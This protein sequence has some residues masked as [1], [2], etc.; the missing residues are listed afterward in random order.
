MTTHFTNPDFLDKNLNARDYELIDRI[1]SPLVSGFIAEFLQLCNP[2]SAYVSCGKPE[3]LDYVRKKAL[4][5]R[6]ELPLTIS[7]HTVH[8]DNYLDQARD[9]EHSKILVPKPEDF[10]LGLRLCDRELCYGEV[11][12]LLRDIMKGREMFISFYSLGPVNSYFSIPCI[13]IT[14]SSYVVHSENILYRQG[15]EEFVRLGAG[16]RPFRFLH[17]EGALDSNMTSRNL[18]KRRVYIDLED[19]TVYSINTQYAGNTIGLKKLG[20]RLAIRRASMEGWLNEHMFIMAVHGPQGRR[21]YFTGAFP[22]MCGKTSTAMIE[23]ESIV[24]DD[25]AFLRAREGAIRA[26]NTEKGMFGIIKDVNAK[27]DPPLWRALNSPGDVIFS[28][29]LTTA[30]G[31][32][33][34]E[35]MGVP[36]PDNGRNHSGEWW[37]GK[38]DEF[39]N[40]IPLSHPNARFCLALQCLSN[41]DPEWD[42]PDGVMVDGII[43][44]GRDY[45][46][47]V[48][49]QE[50]FGWVHGI[51][52]LGASLESETT[53]AT[54]GKAGVRELNPMANLDFLS[55]PVSRYIA[56]NIE[57]GVNFEC[58]PKIFGVNY[59]LRGGR[60]EF[61]TGRMDKQ[62]WLKWMELRVHEEVGFIETPTGRIPLYPDLK[63]LF[64]EVLGMDYREDAYR[65]QFLTRVPE[66]LAK[67]DRV[68]RAY[69][70]IQDIPTVLYDMFK[71]QRERLR[72]VQRKLGDYVD[73][74]KLVE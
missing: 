26:V 24:G 30:D 47:S 14:D 34:W 23:G 27:D 3:D 17:S 74:E 56:G 13:Q 29:V 25:I 49:V 53:A 39:K 44:G 22:S 58:P 6:E 20:M 15:Y 51:I 67:L 57:F 46:T 32:V 40:S 16:V 8:Y 10:G 5:D 61:L 43:Y 4:K 70:E 72:E 60:G 18:D 7:G 73:P 54:L 42:S 45:D 1:K 36:I 65:A 66:N 59:F 55:I 31:N 11:H 2:S 62:V 41:L 48:P 38:S 68:E 21:T 71:Q 35:G 37:S 28:N 33:Y 64:R 52:T 9:R 19:E 50:S 69:R 12:G 63:G